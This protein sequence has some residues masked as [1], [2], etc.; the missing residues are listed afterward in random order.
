MDLQKIKNLIID[1]YEKGIQ[2][3]WIPLTEIENINFKKAKEVNKSYYSD[4][5]IE[6]VMDHDEETADQ[7]IVEYIYELLKQ[8]K[9][10]H[11][12]EL[13]E[14]GIFLIR[15]MWSGS[16]GQLF[17]N[18]TLKSNDLIKVNSLISLIKIAF[19][20]EKEWF[21]KAM[22]REFLV[23]FLT[24]TGLKYEH[25]KPKEVNEDNYQFIKKVV[26]DKSLHLTSFRNSGSKE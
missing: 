19:N 6:E 24:H 23:D 1:S 4:L 8:D 7:V 3:H 22:L 21:A 16:T 12:D 5:T 18:Y 25:S 26:Y 15:K 10:I 9:T 17:Y 13:V 11:L 20:E 2:L 14:A